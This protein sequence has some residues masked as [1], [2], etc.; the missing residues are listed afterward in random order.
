MKHWHT[1]TAAALLLVACTPQEAAKQPPAAAATQTPPAPAEA[2]APAQSASDAPPTV[3]G[4]YIQKGACPGEGCYLKG[5]IKAYDAV[6]LYSDKRTDAAAIARIEKGEWVE[7]LSTEDRFIPL[8]GVVREGK[9]D[10]KTGDIVYMLGY[11]G[12]GCSDVWN[13]GKSSTW[14]DPGSD[15][16]PGPDV[17]DWDAVTP[18]SDT[19]L[20]FWVEVKR[21][22]GQAGWLREGDDGLRKFGCTGY[23]DR[24][25]DCPQLPQ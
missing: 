23:Q 18:S 12:E 9:R 3:N 6:N 17:I 22:N 21:G 24:D 14:C 1:L 11:E 19:T 16:N 20:G 15:P 13:K 4:V 10:H 2:A 25:A 5:K 7:I 8:R